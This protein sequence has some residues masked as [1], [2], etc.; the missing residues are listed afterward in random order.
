M[1]IG[2]GFDLNLG[3]KTGYQNFIQHHYFKS[4]LD[5]KNTL[6]IYLN[7]KNNL[8]RWVDIEAEITNYSKEITKLKD[9]TNITL[10]PLEIKNDFIDLKNTLI[11]YLREEQTK[12]INKES[13]AYKMI[14]DEISSTDIIY[15]FNYTDT[16]FQVSD[17]LCIEKNIIEEKHIYVHGSI[18]DGDIIFGVED[19]A[20]VSS[21]H[22][23]FKKSH[24]INCGKSNIMKDLNITNDLILFGHSLGVTDSTYFSHYISKLSSKGEGNILKFYYYGTSGY[25]E[26]MLVL[27]K[28]TR[29]YLSEFKHKNK[30][31][32][33]DSSVNT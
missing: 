14:Q 4:L 28:Y 3:L 23:F 30:F 29:N 15:N 21:E 22:I 25:D 12:T 32:A 1:V 17:L 18:I 10:S 31:I 8:N 33:I 11:K 26:L 19:K 27:D 6:A 24:H 9:S 7:K 20:E 5:S 16:I 13:I 2:N